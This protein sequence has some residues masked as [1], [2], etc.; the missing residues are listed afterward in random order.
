M[1]VQFVNC[2]VIIIGSLLVFDNF[3]LLSLL[4]IIGWWIGGPKNNQDELV[5]HGVIHNSLAEIEKNVMAVL[6]YGE[7]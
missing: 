1:I 5:A 2:T 3:D 4:T 7:L 6:A